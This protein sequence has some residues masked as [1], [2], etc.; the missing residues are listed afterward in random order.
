MQQPYAT[1]RVAA[2]EEPGRGRHWRPTA[3]GYGAPIATARCATRPRRWS[4]TPPACR[5]RDGPTFTTQNGEASRTLEVVRHPAPSLQ[6][7]SSDR[8]GE[9]FGDAL[10]RPCRGTTLALLRGP[11]AYPTGAISVLTPLKKTLNFAT[12]RR[13]SE[14]RRT[15]HRVRLRHHLTGRRGRDA[16][17]NQESRPLGNR[18]E[19]PSSPHEFFSSCSS[20][21]KHP[22]AVR[23][24][25]YGTQRLGTC[26][27]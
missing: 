23:R 9:L 26:S 27:P 5:S 1:A 8:Q 2:P 25:L 18:V 20:R 11:W 16:A 10:A 14:S 4:S 7:I 13:C 22:D 3:S 12:S 15:K 24:R 19:E 6:T 17:S 21:P